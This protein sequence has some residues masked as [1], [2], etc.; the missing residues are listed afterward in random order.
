LERYKLAADVDVGV[1][2]VRCAFTVCV[3]RG[4]A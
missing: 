3:G 2:L 1:V 4:G